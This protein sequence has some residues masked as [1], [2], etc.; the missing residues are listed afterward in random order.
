[1]RLYFKIIFYIFIG[2]VL[3]IGGLYLYLFQ[4]GGV[5]RIINN[6]ISSLVEEKYLLDIN[7]GGIKG[8]IFSGLIIEDLSV[9]YDDSISRYQLL[10]LP[11]ISTAYS[12]INLWDRKYILDYLILDSAEITLIKDNTGRLLIPDFF[13][14]VRPETK[15]YFSIPSFSVGNFGLN[16]LTLRILENGDTLSFNDIIISLALKREDKTVSVDVEQFEFSSNQ[17]K[18]S[19]DAAGGK[20]TFS[21]NRL[22]FKDLTVVSNETRM[23]LN[24][25][26]LLEQVLS[27]N[28]EF[29]LININLNDITK[30]IGPKLSGVL[31]LNGSVSFVGDSLNGIINIGGDFMIADFQNLFVNFHYANEL[32]SFDTLYGTILENCAIDGNGYID[33]SG[34]KETYR[35]TADIKQF[36]LNN[37]IDNSFNSDLNGN[38]ILDGESFRN[39]DLVLNIYTSLYESSFDEYPLQKVSGNLVVTT[40]SIIFADSFQVDYFENIFYASGKVDYSKGM[41]LLVEVELNNLDRYKGKLFIEQPGGRGYAEA[42]I[43]GKTSDPDLNGF[44]ISDSLWL[45]GLYSDSLYA[46]VNIKRFLTGKKGDIRID[47]FQGTAWDIPYDTGFALL[48]VD[49]NLVFFDSLYIKN[50]YSHLITNGKYDYG[51]YPGLLTVDS[52]MLV[53]FGQPFYNRDSINVNVDSSG[54]DFV[55]ATIGNND[56]KLNVKGRTNYDETMDLY[57]SLNHIPIE[58]WKNLFEESLQVDG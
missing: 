33:F 19:L 22:L 23:K 30:Y 58:P 50:Q 17:K 4:F 12:I 5:E 9:I 1:M 39:R 31:D 27:G 47:F 56:A 36:N 52:L 3:I 24:G 15:S 43:S 6:K 40:D 46:G 21:E 26:V 44:F 7:V 14:K 29:T 54:F 25:Y 13:P 11:R 51:D 34:T 57:L 41:S 45:Y 53:L 28:I 42:V 38:I 37:L 35:L 2:L 20:I 16:H 48:N 8:N 55:Q 10:K 18:V 32:L 49:S